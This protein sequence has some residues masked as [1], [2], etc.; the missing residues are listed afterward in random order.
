MP[1]YMNV[2]D[3]ARR[4]GVDRHTVRRWIEDGKITA[5]SIGE[6][7]FVLHE[8]DVEAAREKVAA[9]R[10]ERGPERRGGAR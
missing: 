1:G 3:A 9:R 8:E 7:G 2:L 6:R 5:E 10:R 4:I